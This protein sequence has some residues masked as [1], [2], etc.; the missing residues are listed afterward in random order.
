MAALRDHG[1]DRP[2]RIGSGG[3]RPA[4]R[5]SRRRRD[6]GALRVV[7]RSD[8][9]SS[10]PPV[11]STTASRPSS[12]P[13][14]A[15]IPTASP[16][17]RPAAS[18][19]TSGSRSPRCPSGAEVGF[20]DVPGHARFI[21][22]MLA[23]VGAVEVAMLVVAANEGWKPQSEEHLRILDLLDVRHGIIVVT[24]STTVDAETL[25]IAQLDVQEHVDGTSFA[26]PRDRHV[27]REGGR[28]T[29]RGARRARPRA[30]RRARRARPRSAAPVG[31]P[32]LRGEGRG[33]GGDRHAHR[34]YRPGRR[35]TL[36]R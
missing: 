25:E 2:H 10:P 7:P 28:R 32:R 21:K 5:R 30:R 16:R 11:T 17:R 20:V 22:N 34:R 35:R 24:K 19:S 3:V 6:R 14:P 4:Q 31:R 18:P 12:S 26:R 29:R 27:R 36:H 1:R 8:R 13:S 15:P 23:G 9:A 33:D